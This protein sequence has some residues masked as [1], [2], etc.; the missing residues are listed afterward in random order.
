MVAVTSERVIAR[1]KRFIEF[2][3]GHCRIVNTAGICGCQVSH[4]DLA[5]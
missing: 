2:S 5:A 3:S 4:D 1:D